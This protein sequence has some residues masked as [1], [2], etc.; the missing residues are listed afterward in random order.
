VVCLAHSIS[1]STFYELRKAGKGPV[2]NE[3][4]RITAEAAAEW[5]RQ[6]DEAAKSLAQS[7]A[8][9]AGSEPGGAG[10]A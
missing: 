5:R 4:N 7:K 8:S 9:A 10:D 2:V 3:L 1:R 6:R